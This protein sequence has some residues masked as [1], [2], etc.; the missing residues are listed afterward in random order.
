MVTVEELKDPIADYV[1]EHTLPGLMP[2]ADIRLKP[3]GLIMPREFSRYIDRIKNFTV[4]PDDIWVI[5]Y[6]KCGT[7]WTQEMVW[8]LGNDLDYEGSKNKLLF[9]RFPFLE[10]VGI[11]A[12]SQKSGSEDEEWVFNADT[13]SYAEELPSP[14]FIKSH[15]PVSLLPDQ[16]WTVKPKI[17]YV[18][19]NVKDAAVSYYHHH[20]LWNGYTG[21]FPLFMQAFLE[22]KVVYSPFWEHLLEYKKLENEPNILINS[23]EEM[24][25]DLP[26]VIRK[27]ANFLGKT[28]TTEQIEVLADHLSF[29]KMKTN[30][31]INGEELIKEVKQRHGLDP[32]DPTLNFIRKG[33]V[34]SWKV[35]MSPDVARQFDIW[36]QKKTKGTILESMFSS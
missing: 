11:I 15:L 29:E 13:I 27:T 33:E 23:F 3:S 18:T 32:S 20:R 16:I 25:K 19:R 30:A 6:P 1:R 12:D 7:T 31:A 36:T 9:Q 26:S 5:S 17:I 10:A 24:K 2:V 21:V 34:G 22:D 4:R 8:L 28:L 35:E 14:R